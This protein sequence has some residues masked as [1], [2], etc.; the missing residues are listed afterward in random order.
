MNHHYDTDYLDD[1]GELEE[2]DQFLFNVS[3]QPDPQ[4][5]TSSPPPSASSSAAPTPD[6]T[7]VFPLP[8]LRAMKG[9]GEY[10][11]P[12]R[13]IEAYQFL[14]ERVL[15]FQRDYIKIKEDGRWVTVPRNHAVQS[16]LQAFGGSKTQYE[17]DKKSIRTFLDTEIHYIEAEGVFPGYSE[18]VLFQ[19]KKYLNTWYDARLP[20]IPAYIARRETILRMI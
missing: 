18:F 5:S 4:P 15:Q 13:E 20:A 11:F 12:R 10:K 19:N 17:F 6:E 16:I 14:A 2:V 7:I 8:P 1:F 3:P 9:I